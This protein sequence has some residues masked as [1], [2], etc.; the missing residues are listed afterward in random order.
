MLVNDI[1][2]QVHDSPLL[3]VIPHTHRSGPAPIA[4]RAAHRGRHRRQLDAGGLRLLP[5]VCAGPLEDRGRRHAV[6]PR[7]E[8]VPP[9]AA[10]SIL[11]SVVRVQPLPQ[12]ARVDADAEHGKREDRRAGETK[13][14]PPARPV[15]LADVDAVPRREQENSKKSGHVRDREQHVRVV[16]VQR[17]QPVRDAD[18][19][20]WDRGALSDN[21]FP[22]NTA[23]S[24]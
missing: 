20:S 22:G 15:A 17:Q 24:L 19:L 13:R 4:A 3:G 5:A 12:S 9:V 6:Q 1:L 7:R 16:Q 10:V 18:D 14:G 23:L 8:P 21:E 11:K 2:Y